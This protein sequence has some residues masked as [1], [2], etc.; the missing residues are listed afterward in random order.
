MKSYYPVFLS[1]E[2]RKILVAGG[3]EVACRKVK[4]TVSAG[5]DVLLVSPELCLELQEVLEKERSVTWIRKRIDPPDIPD[6]IWLIIAATSEPGVQQMLFHE[7]ERRKIFCNVVDQPEISSFIVPSSLSFGDLEVAMS[8]GGRSPAVAKLARREL[9]GYFDWKWA[10]FLD[11]AGMFRKVVLESDLSSE[12]KGTICSA[13]GNQDV[14]TW[15]SENR[16]DKITHWMS[17]IS[18]Y[19]LEEELRPVKSYVMNLKQDAGKDLGT[20]E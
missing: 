10:A 18:G 9:Q 3:G 4:K 1:L 2:G 19:E 11:I 7:A 15:L 16:M 5:A 20:D 6:D 17:E 14:L 8:T 12:R 13:M